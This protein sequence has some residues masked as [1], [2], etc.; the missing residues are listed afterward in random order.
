MSEGTEEMDAEGLGRRKLL[1]IRF[2]DLRTAPEKQTMGTVT[3]SHK[4]LSLQAL[5]G[6]LRQSVPQTA[7]SSCTLQIN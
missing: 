6:S 4:M 5:L 3:A 7:A 2:G 1:L